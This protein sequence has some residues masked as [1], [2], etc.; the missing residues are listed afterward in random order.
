MSGGSSDDATLGIAHW[1]GERAV[2]DLLVN[3]G[4]APPF[5]PRLAVARFAVL[6]KRYRCREVHGDAYA[7]QTFRHD[8]S[9]LGIDYIVEKQTRS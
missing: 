8:F 6:C 1:N 5:N 9:D 7:R 4:D 3:Q 2:L